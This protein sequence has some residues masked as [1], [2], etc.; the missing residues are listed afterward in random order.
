M[1]KIFLSLAAVASLSAAHAQKLGDVFVNGSIGYRYANSET[2]T[3]T[4][5]VNGPISH[6]FLL[7]P[8]VGYQFS[9]NWG[10]GLM[11]KYE[12]NSSKS[13]PSGS[14]TEV[15]STSNLFG[16]GPFLRYTKH[17]SP[18]FFVNGQ[19]NALYVTGKATNESAGVTSTSGRANGVD[20][21]VM[22]S[23]GINITRTMAVTGAFG[24]LGYATV[25]NEDPSNSSNYLRNNAFDVTFGREFML[26]VQWNFATDGGRARR[27]RRE[28]MSET[29]RM[30][31]YR[32]TDTDTETTEEAPRRRER[33]DRRDRD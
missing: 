14:T 16:I 9:R 17:L 19:L 26:G 7:S 20:V 24:R 28:P 32:D 5:T 11:V 22:P 15:K 13:T 10:A 33:R 23:I 25:K 12:Y 6:N 3:G 4:T 18:M 27:S 30:D 29:R 21:N 1:K 31:R 2:N 8:S